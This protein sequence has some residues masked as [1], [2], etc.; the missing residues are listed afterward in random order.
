[1][2]ESTAGKKSSEMILSAF[3][4]G[5]QKNKRGSLMKTVLKFLLY[6][7]HLSS[8]VSRDSSP[9]SA[10]I[11]RDFNPESKSEVEQKQHTGLLR[12]YH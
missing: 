12:G 8:Q 11:D 4:A 2:K 1:M 9:P 6:V 10:I 7:P 5:Y 3:S